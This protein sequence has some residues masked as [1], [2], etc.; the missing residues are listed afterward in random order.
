MLSRRAFVAA[1][2]STLAT[3]GA[4][5]EIGAQG[6]AVVRRSIGAMAA[7][8]PD[9]VAYRRAVAAMKALPPADPRNWYRFANIH[10]NFCPHGNWYFLPWHRAYLAAFERICR[11]L[12]G[13]PDF[14][15][16]YWDWTAQRRLPP[17]FVA[18]NAASN[19]LFHPRTLANALPDDMVGRGVMARV[20]RSPDFEAFGSTRPDGQ[21]SPDR[22]WLRR[23]G[24][25]TELEF[26]PHDGVHI[27]LGGDM[28]QV[29]LSSRDPIFWLHHGNIDRLWAS[30][31]QLGHDNSSEPNWL[32]FGFER[33]FP[34]P[35]G[36]A[37]NVA[38]SDLQTTAAL[39]YE[40]DDVVVASAPDNAMDAYAAGPVL[41]DPQYGTLDRDVPPPAPPGDAPVQRGPNPGYVRDRPTPAIRQPAP[42]QLTAYRQIDPYALSRSV[43]GARRIALT[44]GEAFY[45]S[46]ADNDLAASRER[47]IGIA[48]PFSRP[49]QQLIGP[50]LEGETATPS[51]G[52]QRVWATLREIE[53]PRDKTTRLRVFANCE[54][55]SPR[56]SL[57]DA[58][59]ATSVS[60]FSG[61]HTQHNGGRHSSV[62]IDLTPTL[63]QMHRRKRLRGDRIVLQLLPVCPGG[64]VAASSVRPRRIDIA[65]I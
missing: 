63:R 13:K 5:R 51:P 30:W 49:L 16:P 31:N 21:N 52:T 27:A 45:F 11:Q 46:T 2:A 47:P 29:P 14:A 57:D 61:D 24:T 19:P 6:R 36:S 28:A 33:Q 35:D 59:Y 56:T 26:N 40:Y 64:D 65:L 7:N 53:P 17:A 41:R 8:D 62:S 23:E 15:L 60:F 55:L 1:G 37:W 50:A 39:G 25:R 48:V 4:I 43:R 42:S 44:S 10:R 9:L 3:F 38:V 20:L 34:N 18:G 22:G 32:E 54:A 12:S 58:S